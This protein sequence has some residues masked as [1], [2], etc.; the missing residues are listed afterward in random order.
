M[1][2]NRI[3]FWLVDSA[4]TY[5]QLPVNPESIDYSNPYGINTLSIASLGEIALPGERGL[6]QIT[7]SSFFPRDYNPSYCEYDGFMDPFSW[8]SHIQTWRYKRE[9]IRLVITGTPISLPMFISEFNVQPENAG[10]PGDMYFTITFVEYRPFKAEAIQ[11]PTTK[12]TAKASTKPSSRPPTA[13]STPK[14]YTVKKGDSLSLISKKVY[15]DMTK[16]KTIYNAN[17]SVIGKNPDV[18]KAGQKLVIP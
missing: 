17:K 12:L 6:K 11:A 15:G 10:S 14:T 3:G 7:F 13:K 8:F 16:W 9:P 5:H 4:N 2:K 1:A 18:I